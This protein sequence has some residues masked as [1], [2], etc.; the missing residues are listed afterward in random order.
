MKSISFTFY[1]L[2]FY[3]MYKAI[4]NIQQPTLICFRSTHDGFYIEIT[5]SKQKLSFSINFK[6]AA[7]T[8]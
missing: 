2:A 7:Q 1:V 3:Y 5:K 8:V 4:Y 6:A